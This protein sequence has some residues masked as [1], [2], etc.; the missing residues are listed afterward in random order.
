MFSMATSSETRIKHKTVPIQEKLE[1]INKVGCYFSLLLDKG[2]AADFGV[3]VSN[4][5][6][7]GRS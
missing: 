1:I 4:V 3:S 2:I 6:T 5:N 7:V